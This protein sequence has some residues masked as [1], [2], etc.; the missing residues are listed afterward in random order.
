MLCAP[1]SAMRIFSTHFS[2]SVLDEIAWPQVEAGREQLGL[3][4]DEALA[5]IRSAERF[6]AGDSGRLGRCLGCVRISRR[7]A[8][9]RPAA[10]PCS[11]GTAISGCCDTSI[12]RSPRSTTA[13]PSASMNGCGNSAKPLPDHAPCRPRPGWAREHRQS[14]ADV[15]DRRRP[16]VTGRFRGSAV[17]T[18]VTASADRRSRSR[19]VADRRLRGLRADADRVGELS[20][21]SLR[22]QR[23][24]RRD[25][26]SQQRAP[27]APEG[28]RRFCVRQCSRRAGGAPGGRQGC[29]AVK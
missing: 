27:Y 21:A 4:R 25:G 10:P 7:G 3:A 22:A 18:K 24:E 16:G 29:G 12:S 15:V 14:R 8:V 2:W 9:C 23:R 13:Q 6:S 11:A 1:A 26:R 5:L 20:R 28:P 19:A 17:S